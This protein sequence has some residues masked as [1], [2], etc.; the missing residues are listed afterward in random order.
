MYSGGSKERDHN[1]SEREGDKNVGFDIF[2]ERK[3]LQGLDGRG[4]RRRRSWG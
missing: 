1:A 4:I 2:R 3:K